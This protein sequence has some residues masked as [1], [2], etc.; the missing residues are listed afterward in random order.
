MKKKSYIAPLGNVVEL[1][2]TSMMAVSGGQSV[3]VSNQVTEDD[4][5]MSKSMDAG[6]SS[7]WE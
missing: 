5:A 4:A 7:F 3:Y 6:S 2:A 1:E